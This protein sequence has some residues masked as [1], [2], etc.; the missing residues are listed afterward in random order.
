LIVGVETSTDG[1]AQPLDQWN[2]EFVPGRFNSF[3]HRQEVRISE[4]NSVGSQ[5]RQMVQAA[6]DIHRH[7]F[8]VKVPHHVNQAGN[9][10]R[11]TDRPSTL[12]THCEETKQLRSSLDAGFIHLREH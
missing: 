3:E 4:R 10:F 11:R 7:L 1:L 2:H 9:P 8:A 12:V 5:V 6:K